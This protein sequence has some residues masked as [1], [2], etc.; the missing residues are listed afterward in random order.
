M[1]IT[2]EMIETA[3]RAFCHTEEASERRWQRYEGAAR[4]AL[5]AAIAV[6]EGADMREAIDTEGRK[7]A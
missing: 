4:W 3:A 2:A 6:G 5:T 1:E 7:A